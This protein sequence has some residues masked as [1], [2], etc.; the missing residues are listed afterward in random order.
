MTNRHFIIDT[1]TASDDAVAI[2]MALHWPD[3]T[4]DAITTVYGN[5][6]L[7]RASA[8][9]RYSVEFCGQTT[10]VYEGCVRPLL[11]PAVHAEWFHGADGMGKLGQLQPQRPAAEKH[12]VEE[13]I[14]R[15]RAAPGAI[16]LVTLGPL[17]NLAAALSIEPRL[18]GWV[19]E[20]YIM[21]GNANCVGN[22]TPAAE[23]NI[24]CDPEA[25]RIVFHAGIKCLMVGWEHCRFDAALTDDEMA[26]IRALDTP[27]AHFA[28][29]CNAHALQ[30]G[31]ESQG[32]SGMMLPDP[33]TMAIALDPRVCTRRSWHYV[34]V[35]CAE[36]LTRGMTV[37]DELNVTDHKPNLEVC[38][39]IDRR[40]WKEILC[41]TLH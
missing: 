10:P 31:R 2:I 30:V 14:R 39:E 36:E 33:I 34:D 38:W 8:N 27:R 11:R 41:Q 29:D 4:V 15:F 13:L 5:V 21:G 18:A 12:A 19:K 37:V 20:C 16:T 24:W 40:L 22:V 26:A 7:A 28:L 35:A 9:A 25:A 32:A 3:V 23:F 1:D 6:P 17:T